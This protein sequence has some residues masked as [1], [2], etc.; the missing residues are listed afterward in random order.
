MLCSHVGSREGSWIHNIQCSKATKI[1]KDDAED[2]LNEFK[3]KMNDAQLEGLQDYVEKYDGC[4][5]KNH[6]KQDFFMPNGW[7]LGKVNEDRPE[8]PML[9][10]GSFKDGYQDDYKEHQWM[11]DADGNKVEKKS[12]RRGC[13]KK[14]KEEPKAEEPKAEEP[15]ELEN[16]EV[17]VAD[18]VPEDDGA[19]TGLK[20]KE[21]EKEEVEE[22]KEEVQE[23]EDQPYIIDGVEYTNVWDEDDEEWLVTYDGEHVGWPITDGESEQINFADPDEEDKHAKRV[24]EL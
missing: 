13:G 17:E 18:P 3:D 14:K 19:G 8:K 7:W 20:P 22:K 4:F 9:P 15:V 12:G 23:K 10:K 21:E 1:S 16:V 6:L 2:I 11:Y 5:C 24:E